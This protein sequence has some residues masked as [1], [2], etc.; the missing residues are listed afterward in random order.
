MTELDLSEKDLS[1][2]C[3]RWQIEQL[4]LFGSTLSG[5]ARADSDI[6]LL[7]SFSKSARWSLLDHI[8]MEREL[9]ALVG[10]QVDLVSK[11]AVLRSD[12]FL[13][14]DTVLSHTQTVY[15]S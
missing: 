15:G 12:N 8:K 13:R 3:S 14:R 1:G 4:E 7:V 9:S 5:T 2:F 6:D 11:R 10:K